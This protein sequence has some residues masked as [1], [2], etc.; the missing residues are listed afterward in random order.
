MGLFRQRVSPASGLS[1]QF[2][3]RQNKSDMIKNVLLIDDDPFCNRMNGFVLERYVAP[4]AIVTFENAM[5]ALKYL[6][7]LIIKGDIGSFPDVLL[8][9][10]HMSYMDGWG[11]LDEFGK[12]PASFRTRAQ[13]FILTSSIQPADK[14][15]A[16]LRTDVSGYIE[17]PF[18]LAELEYVVSYC[19]GHQPRS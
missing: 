18:T 16:K 13:V 7:G 15:R 9:D 2:I 6:R 17:K 14:E 4:D 5:D 10:L 1:L 11:F 19:G 8:L 3:Y 12:L